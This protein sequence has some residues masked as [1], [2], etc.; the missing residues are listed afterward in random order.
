MEELV[1][2]AAVPQQPDFPALEERVQKRWA[3]RD[4]V[5]RALDANPQGPPFRFNEGPPTANGAPGVHHIEARVFKDLF[6]RYRQMKGYRV[7][8]KAGWDCHGIPVE[9]EVE[10]ELGFTRKQDIED[11]GVATF[12]ARCRESVQRYVEE[13]NALTERIAFWVDMEEAYWT[14]NADYVESVWWSLRR[15]W[16][17]GFIYRGHRVVPWCPR[18]GTA[19]SDH[20]VA[21]G[22]AQTDDPSVHVRLPVRTGPLAEEGAALLVWTTTPWTLISNTAVAVG[23]DVRYVL[24]DAGA[25]G[26][27]VLA[28]DL[29][30][31][32]LGEDVHVVRDVGIDELA[33]A[34]YQGP[35]E[36]VG[37]GTGYQE[38]E[39]GSDWRTV[40]TADFV[41]TEEGTGLVHLA[42][43][44]GADD[45]EA[46]TALDVPVVNPVDD[47]GRFTSG[48]TPFAGQFVKDADP[49]IT[50]DLD[51]RG[52][53]VASGT[54]T[55]TYPFCWRCDTPLLYTA[56]PSWYIA[57]TR[58]RDRLLEV[59]AGVDWHPEHIRDG[60]F[61]DWL[62]NNVDW[63][64]S[65]E[66]YWGTPL[67]LWVCDACD[68]VTAVG[69]LA[70]LGERAGRD[71]S[72]MDP[73]R[74]FVDEVTFPCEE[75]GD[76]TAGRVPEVIDAW[77]DSGAMP[78][79]QF[80]YP[81][82]TGSHEA[83]AD[84][85]PADYICEAIDQTR[86]WFYSLMA[87]STLL[88]DRNSYRTV[89]CLGHIVDEQGRKM[90]KR[91]GNVIDPWELIGTKGADAVR[92]LMLT[93]GSPWVTRRV[94]YEIVDGVVRKV[95]LTLWNTFYFF[96]TYA[97]LDGWSPADADPPP[98]SERPAMDRWVLAELA[99]VV[100]VVDDRLAAYD[101][102]TAGRRL[103]EFIDD[104]SNW[105]V[106]RTRRRF[107]A[108]AGTASDADKQAA[109]ATLHTCLTEL[110]R[111]LAPFT[112]FLAEELYEQ[113]ASAPAAP[114]DGREPRDSVHLEAFPT[115]DPAAEDEEL[116]AA[117]ATARHVT[118]LGRKAREDA[119]VGVRQP[120][121]RALVSLPAA[122]RERWPLVADIVAD[123]L[124]VRELELPS[125]ETAAIT[126]RLKANYRALGPAFGQRTPVVAEAI[127]DA[128]PDTVAESLTERGEAR[129]AVDGEMVTVTEEQVQVI[130][131]SQ[132][133]FQ[134][135][136]DAGY[137][138]ALDLELD[139]ELRRA[140]LA[141]EVVRALN[142][143]RKHHDLALDARISLELGADDVLTDAIATHRE[144]V[145]GEVLA[146]RLDVRDPDELTGSEAVSIGDR[147]LAVRLRVEA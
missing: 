70:E 95:M 97:R 145:A 39:S 98:V 68:H 86:G 44:F 100:R 42:P 130:E 2:F 37:P 119:G 66:R 90:S 36:L 77:Y 32:V 125:D 5:N 79:A 46:A 91:L 12:N 15:L 114:I 56:K 40:T 131:E 105:Y 8:R 60:R 88:F 103:Q 96:T 31:R 59:N 30:E 78:F 22:Y 136:S 63:S 99:D 4:V 34:A 129:V 102:T 146:S 9:L 76:G 147:E 25:H 138:V 6:P 116:R 52:L 33:G 101:A 111:L 87:V 107:W 117:M 135:A 73:H 67:P 20:E 62:A 38:G 139:E 18:C 1:G 74:P 80:G 7:P 24:A 21:Q 13:W 69:S 35:F 109:F 127:T 120:L 17:E 104:L 50:A 126:R 94:G 71:L 133:G 122:E 47:E 28:A 58:I 48:I 128:D 72:T 29:V 61:G 84:H 81:H 54:Y 64:L 142:E 14:M 51:A 93:D 83:F 57:T 113:L 124:N 27:V 144:E 23:P 82:A 26:R 106:R 123:E 19:L 10:K 43:A 45:L 115:P 41:T 134:V 11:Y 3:A 53:L 85:F 143:L 89:L 132:T 110:A 141:R 112:P 137:S 108:P 92:W 55:H 49:A 75:C 118:A 121:R 140:G 16:D 65:R